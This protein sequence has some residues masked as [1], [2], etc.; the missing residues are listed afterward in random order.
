MYQQLSQFA[1]LDGYGGGEDAAARDSFSVWIDSPTE[2]EA[3]QMWTPRFSFRSSTLSVLKRY[4]RRLSQFVFKSTP[5][6]HAQTL[7]YYTPTPPQRDAKGASACARWF[8]YYWHRIVSKKQAK[9]LD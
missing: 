6:A 9:E 4:Y 7:P 1:R 8:S 3:H 2:S 5:H